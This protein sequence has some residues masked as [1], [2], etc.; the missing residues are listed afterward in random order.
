MKD[1]GQRNGP[2]AHTTASQEITVVNK[3][4][5]DDLV[6]N[7]TQYLEDILRRLVALEKKVEESTKPTTKRPTK[8]GE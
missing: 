3:A 6:K 1:I 7:T 8:S 2:D 5:F 4:D